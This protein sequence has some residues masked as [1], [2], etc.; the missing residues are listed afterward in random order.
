METKQKD[1]DDAA[2]ERQIDMHIEP[3]YY[4]KDYSGDEAKR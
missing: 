4:N 1:E 2:Y 3:C